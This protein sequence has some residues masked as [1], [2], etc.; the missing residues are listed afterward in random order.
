M[1]VMSKVTPSQ[2]VSAIELMFTSNERLSSEGRTPHSKQRDVRAL[3]DLLDD[4]P[5]E[6]IN[7][8]FAEF[9]EFKQQ[10]AALAT[11]LPGWNLGSIPHESPHF[12]KD[13]CWPYFAAKS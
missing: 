8:P 13:S 9:L 12:V 6:L 10:R 5:S 7:L 3:L 4:L 11:A 2:V 1:K